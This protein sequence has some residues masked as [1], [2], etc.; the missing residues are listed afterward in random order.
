MIRRSWAL[1]VLLALVACEAPRDRDPR[2]NTSV[3]SGFPNRKVMDV[4]ILAPKVTAPDGDLLSARFRKE[5]RAVLI[6]RKLYSVPQDAYVDQALR[7]LPEATGSPEK[8]ASVTGSDAT[9][10]IV[11]SQWETGELFPRGRIFAGGEMTLHGKDAVLW[12]RSFQDKMLLAPRDVTTTNRTQTIDVMI[13][14]L[15]RELMTTLPSKP[16]E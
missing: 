1:M 16:S 4:A 14:D 12:K 2:E 3:E 13:R 6:D 7:N 10:E 9:L 15:T 11:V 8:L 5:A